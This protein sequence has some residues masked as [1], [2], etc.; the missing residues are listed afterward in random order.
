MRA[1]W[2]T[3]AG[4]VLIA[5]AAWLA[6]GDLAPTA[7]STF[8]VRL[9]APGSIAWLVGVFAAALA[10]PSLRRF[11]ALAAPA[12]LSIL[13]WLPLPLPAIAYLWTGKLAWLPVALPFAGALLA[14][15]GSAGAR[16]VARPARPA[17]DA[18]IAAVLTLTVAVATAISLRHSIPGGDEPH[19][20]VITQSLLQDGDLRIENNH[21]ARDYEAYFEGTIDPQSIRR[22]V[23]GEIYPIHMPGVSIFVAPLFVLFGYRGAQA[24]IVVSAAATGAVVWLIAWI[25]TRERSAAWFAWTS[26][27]GSATFLAQSATVFPDL[28]AAT[29]TALAA[30]VIARIHRGQPITAL[31]VASAATILAILPFLHTRFAVLSGG[32]GLTLVLVLV[33]RLQQSEPRKLARAI[34]AFAVPALAGMAVWFGY[35]WRIYGTPNPTAP[36]GDLAESSLGYVPG[37]VVGLAFDQQFGLLAYSPVLALAFAPALVRRSGDRPIVLS[38]LLTAAAYAAAVATYWMWWAGGPAPPARFLTA[39]LPLLA[40]PLAETWRRA[41]RSWR[42]VLCLLLGSSLA[43]SSI[44]I[45]ADEGRLY[46]NVRNARALWLEWLG[47]ALDLPRLW[48]SFFWR[49]D[50][51]N[52]ATEWLF[53][54]DAFIWL[55]VFA[56]IG[57]LLRRRVTGPE[58][59]VLH[60]EVSVIPSETRVLGSIATGLWWI[61]VSVMIAGSATIALDRGELLA[62]ALSQLDVLQAATDGA[63]VRIAPGQFRR[64]RAEDVAMRIAVPRT[65]MPGVSTA[66]WLVLPNVPAGR[67]DVVVTLKRP[68]DGGTLEVRQ[69]RAPVP[70]ASFSLTPQSVQTFSITFESPI[71]AL[72][73]VPNDVLASIAQSIELVRVR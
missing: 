73:L 2:R 22:G 40:L 36:Y 4:P 59:P 47:G 32:L 25:A 46:A 55:S 17:F 37:G 27:V 1:G 67:Y 18:A 15:V 70:L 69:G 64:A 3:I 6:A 51:S 30:L 53:A 35:F 23:D 39:A 41:E 66:E 48:P 58:T 7:V 12:V 44:V 20:L 34:T 62:P 13:P 29:G 28:P 5:V 10:V 63:L 31:S 60:P 8:N 71:R 21:Q 24:T 9:G 42:P 54:R 14:R 49:L 50:P 61:P 45:F 33:R 57:W 68:R 72:W 43:V 26:I 16:R 11:P 56:G 38:L 52:L 65:E 19:Y